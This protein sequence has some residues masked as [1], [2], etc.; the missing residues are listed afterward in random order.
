M[1]QQH[2]MQLI[3]NEGSALFAI[4]AVNCNQIEGEKRAASAYDVSRTTWRRRC[5]GIAAR[6]DCEP[7]SKKLTKYEELA[8]FQYVLDLNSRGFPP[9]KGAVRDMANKLLQ[10]RDQ[11]ERNR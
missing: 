5:D 6:R 2:N 4:Q 11:T 10:G 9:T 1:Q 3:Y 8:I 7:N